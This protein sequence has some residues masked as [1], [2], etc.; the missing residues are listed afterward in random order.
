[1]KQEVKKYCIVGVMEHYE[2]VD[3]RLNK[4]DQRR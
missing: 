4:R 2:Y 3:D 1:V